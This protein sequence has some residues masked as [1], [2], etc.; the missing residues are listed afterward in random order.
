MYV[1]GPGPALKWFESYLMGR[2]QSVKIGYTSSAPHQLR[3][4][5][6]QGS[7]LEPQLFSVSS[8]PLGKIIKR[9]GLERHFYADDSQVYF[10]VS[11]LQ[12][13]FDDKIKIVLI[14][15]NE[16]RGWMIANFLKNN[17]EKLEIILFGSPQQLKKL[18]LDS[19][20]IG[21]ATVLP[22]TVVKNL[23]VLEDSNFTMV[24]HINRMR[25]LAYLQLR[26]I[27]RIR[28]FL[29]QKNTEKLVH[30]FVTSRLDIGNTLLY[31]LP[32]KELYRLQTIQNH[33]ARVVTRTAR[34]EHI[35]PVLRKLHWLPIKQRINFKILVLAYK[36]LRDMAP[37]YISE[38]I[39]HLEL[40]SGLRSATR[41]QLEQPRSS[42]CWG[43]R[44]FSH[45]APFLWNKLPFAI[46]EKPTL[47]SFKSS[48]KTFIF[49]HPL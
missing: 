32:D 1:C 20:I 40:R 17:D 5:V 13:D 41:G 9:H 39:T 29:S 49:N 4:S 34:Y 15:I 38:L 35:S 47:S 37:L 42:S 14:C 43:D 3:Y 48:L 21:D 8:A 11:P 18:K 10:S 7:V 19:I 36:S 16:I 2:K 45:A 25:S 44:A 26:D 27:S 30:A 46:K 28:A 33:A 22:A 6:P 24:Q 23:G 31:R 12:S